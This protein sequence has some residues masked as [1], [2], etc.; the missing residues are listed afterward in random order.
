MDHGA[1]GQSNGMR[2]RAPLVFL[3]FAAIAGFFLVTEHRAHLLGYLPWILLLAFPLLHIFMHGGHGGHGGHG[4][5]DRV[6]QETSR[7]RENQPGE[8]PAGSGTHHH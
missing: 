7:R 2:W 4:T 3:I 6:D 8:P 5:H 1:H